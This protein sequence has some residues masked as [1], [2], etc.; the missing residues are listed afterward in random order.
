[1]GGTRGSGCRRNSVEISVPGMCTLRGGALG[2]MEECM[3]RAAPFYVVGELCSKW[4]PQWR[5]THSR[6]RTWWEDAGLNSCRLI[7]WGGGL[8]ARRA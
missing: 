5:A 1:M 6:S 4:K 2:D 8:N 7:V 3:R